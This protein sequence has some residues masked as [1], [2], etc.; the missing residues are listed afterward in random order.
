MLSASLLILAPFC[1]AQDADGEASSGEYT[2]E[3]FQKMR[4]K[5][6][7]RFL[8]ARGVECKGCS[9]KQDYVSTAF[10]NRDTPV[11]PPPEPKEPSKDKAVDDNMD[12]IM[13]KMRASGFAGQVF[14]GD[15]LKGLSAEEIA[16]K[17]SAGGGA[18]RS[19]P[20]GSGSGRRKK[21]SKDSRQKSKEDR[22]RRKRSEEETVEL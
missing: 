6:L 9:E 14:T 2:R 4:A 22:E 21:E 8:R 1:I 13:A 3:K 20:S 16:A 11:I 19:G 12:D 17:L 15:D 7:A 18:S 10:D 5:E